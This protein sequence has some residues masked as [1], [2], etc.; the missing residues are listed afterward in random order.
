MATEVTLD[1][2]PRTGPDLGSP[3][4]RRLRRAGFVPATVYGHGISAV[5]AAVEERALYRALHTD[6]G[7][8]VLVT[9]RFDDGKEE[10]VMPR[11]VVRHPVKDHYVHLDFLRISRTEK[12]TVD[13]GVVLV[14]D[15]VGVQEGGIVEQQTTAVQVAA[16]ATAVPD[17]LEVNVESLDIGDSATVADL[18]VPDGV[19]VLTD[20]ETTVASIVMVAAEV[21][22]APAEGEELAEGEEALAEEEGGEETEEPEGE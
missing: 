4:S 14:G 9:L 6:A 22:E 7:S 11:D 19:E 2:R 1:A 8:N 16:L 18:V 21:E 12:V 5:S 13:V 17:Q 15:P 20:P 3:G 10:L